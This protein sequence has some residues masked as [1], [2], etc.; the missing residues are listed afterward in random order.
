MSAFYM[1][2]KLNLESF[3][4]NG[5]RRVC[6]G[7]FF[8]PLVNA[9]QWLCLAMEMKF[10]CQKQKVAIYSSAQTQ[11]FAF[12]RVQVEAVVKK[13]RLFFGHHH[14]CRAS[15]VYPC[16][17]VD[18][19][20]LCTLA[21]EHVI[22]TFRSNNDQLCPDINFLFLDFEATNENL[23]FSLFQLAPSLGETK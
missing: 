5:P 6:T 14:F 17:H 11:K 9:S 7:I 10:E 18:A 4:V 21:T 22:K 12:A 16:T 23:F 3:M 15:R 8:D 13:R 20:N 1:V 2:N 19:L